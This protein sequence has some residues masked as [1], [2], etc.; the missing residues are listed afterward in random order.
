MWKQKT[1]RQKCSNQTLTSNWGRPS[2]VSFIAV[3]PVPNVAPKLNYLHIRKFYNGTFYQKF[4]SFLNKIKQFTFKKM[5][6]FMLQQLLENKWQTSTIQ[7]VW[8]KVHQKAKWIIG[9][10]LPP[11]HLFGNF[12]SYSSKFIEWFCILFDC[13]IFY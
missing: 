11:L 10:V 8:T 2:A 13:L 4:H 7:R 1:Q 3:M 6:S 5:N 9:Y 12:E